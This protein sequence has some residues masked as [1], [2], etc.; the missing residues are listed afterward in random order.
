[1]AHIGDIGRSGFQEAWTREDGH[2]RRAGA[3]R[4]GRSLA[5]GLVMAF[6]V[7]AVA[8]A[9]HRFLP[10]DIP[11]PAPAPPVLPPFWASVTRPQP[12]FAVTGLPADAPVAHAARSHTGK[13]GEEDTL[14]LG[15]FA[16]GEHA[17]LIVERPGPEP[18]RAAGFTID[19]VRRA[20][21]AGVTIARAGQ[22][23][24]VETR[25]GIAEVAPMQLVREGVARGC[26][27][28]RLAAP[29]DLLRM[30]GWLC[31]SVPGD[32]PDPRLRCLIEAV[33]LAGPREDPALTRLF[34][35]TERRRDPAC[36]RAARKG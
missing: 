2:A 5:R 36:L 12:V 1:M 23:V 9:I 22:P 35:A 8:A 13:A 32:G 24:A 11:E 26:S 21:E 33:A 19:I 18:R 25:F 6:G 17:R 7:L 28:F 29:D 14:I 16:A 31:A 27:V 4:R 34:A 15:A 20:A 30:T 10:A 3:P